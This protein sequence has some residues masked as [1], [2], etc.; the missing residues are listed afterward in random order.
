MDQELLSAFNFLV[1]FLT[2]ASLRASEDG[3]E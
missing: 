2:F 1:M 3:E